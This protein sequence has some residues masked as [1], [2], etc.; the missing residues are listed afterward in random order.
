MVGTWYKITIKP[1]K[2]SRMSAKYK[3]RLCRKGVVYT[4]R[5]KL[6]PALYKDLMSRYATKKTVWNVIKVEKA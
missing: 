1:R 4:I 3:H 5:R 2:T 6:T